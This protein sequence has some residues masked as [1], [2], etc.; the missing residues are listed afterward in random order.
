MGYEKQ[1]MQYWNNEALTTDVRYM[2]DYAL[3]ELHAVNVLELNRTL[4]TINDIN[5]G[6]IPR[7]EQKESK[8]KVLSD[9]VN[10]TSQ[11]DRRLQELE[12]RANRILY[13]L[14]NR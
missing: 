13:T 1:I 12:R 2:F 3:G 14:S 4:N 11:L 10:N 7:K 8:D 6:K 5:L 9:I